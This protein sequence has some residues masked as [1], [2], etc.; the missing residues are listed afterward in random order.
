MSKAKGKEMRA[1][2]SVLFGTNPSLLSLP[3]WPPRP[4]SE[5][6]IAAIVGK[7]FFSSTPGALSR[8]LGGFLV[9]D[10]EMTQ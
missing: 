5:F 4:R 10:P 8:I 1:E 3:R 9:W 6:A 7:R 2:N